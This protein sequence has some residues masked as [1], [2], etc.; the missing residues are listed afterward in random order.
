MTSHGRRGLSKNVTIALIGW[1]IRTEKRGRGSK[2]VK[3]LRDIISGWSLTV[4]RVKAWI[5][6]VIRS[7]MTL[8]KPDSQSEEHLL[9]PKLLRVA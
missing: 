8:L 6:L 2:K 4:P 7:C 1:V 9:G 3:H 5:K